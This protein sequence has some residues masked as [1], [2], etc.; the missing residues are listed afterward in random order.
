MILLDTTYVSPLLAETLINKKTTIFDIQQQV[1]LNRKSEEAQNP[2]DV[3]QQEELMIMNSEEAVQI[4]N[5]YYAESNVTKMANLFKNKFAFRKRL[6]D[7]YPHFFFLETTSAEMGQIDLN[8]LPYPVIFKPTVGYSSAGVYRIEDARE[9]ESIIG[10]LE[11]TMKQSSENYS[12]GVLDSETFIIESYIEGQEFAI[13]LFF[14]ENNNPV[15]LNLFARMFK[16]DK[17]MSDRIYYTSKLVLQSYLAAITEYLQGLG[18][19]FDLR[20]MPLHVEL[21]MNDKGIIVPI[22]INPLRFAG[23]GT[24]EL[25]SFAYGVNP[26]EYFFEQRKPDWPALINAMDN[27]IYNFTCAEFTGEAKIDDGLLIHHNL[28][29]EQFPHILEYRHIPYDKG[30]TFAVIFFSSD[31]LAQNEHI[32]SLDFMEYVEQKEYFFVNK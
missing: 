13:D 22:E 12:K 31:S 20:K 29:Q 21:R 15:V 11:E 18:E 4:L 2:G 3:F 7:N 6:A 30:T 9:F 25:G 19:I 10:K 26:Y 28:L 27:K 32:L 14:D 24:T 8:A 1:F 5:E 23:A 17:D 16:D